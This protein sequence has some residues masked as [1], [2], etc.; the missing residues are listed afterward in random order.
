MSLLRE[1][2]RNKKREVAASKK[3]L[4]EILARK[5]A[6]ALPKKKPSFAPALRRGRPLAV[7][8]EIKRRS[9]SK[10]LLRRDFDPARLA[11]QYKRGGASALSVLTDR[12]YFGGAPEF[13]RRAKTASGLPVLRKDFIVSE[14]QVYESRLLGADAI[15][16]IAAALDRRTM[17]AL[18]RAA[19][20]LGLDTLFE[21]HTAAELEKVRP[22]R[23]R[24]LGVNNRDLRTFRVD[25]AVSEKLSGLIP[26]SALFVSESGIGLPED[27]KRL[28]RC[29]A[30]AALVGESLMTEKDPGR[31]L[32]RLLGKGRVKG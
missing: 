25:L 5:A 4:P 17:A 7:I 19:T 22:L 31:A 18:Y 32:K 8:A 29:G 24:L 28:R 16:L 14:Y 20:R 21:V 3:A 12:R 10:G 13:I 26:K 1:I 27:L 11:R 15:L 30:R 9:P 23:P 6:L 2:L